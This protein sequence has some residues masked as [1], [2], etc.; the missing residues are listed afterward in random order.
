MKTTTRL[1]HQADDREA[2]HGSV[3][4]PIYH[5][6]LYT[7][8]TMQAFLDTRDGL[9]ERYMYSRESNP[10]VRVLEQK[11]AMLEGAEDCIATSSGMAAIT[12]V[13]LSI[14]KGGD[15]ALI[16]QTCYGPTRSF[17]DD[18]MAEL[19]VETTYFHPHV[20]DLSPL[21]QPN[22]RL[23][24]LESPGSVTFHI[25]DLRAL[26]A[27]ARAHGAITMAD[28]S[29]S[30]PLYQQPHS[31]GVD[32]VVHS[33]TK[34]IA[35]HSDLVLGLITGGG[36]QFRRI[37]KVAVLL[38]A[39]LGPAEA[40]LALRSLRTLSVRMAQLQQ[41]TMAVT[42]WLQAHSKVRK[43]LYPGLPSFPRHELAKTQ[44]SGWSSLFTVELQPPLDPEQR[45]NFVDG[46]EL[47]SV[48]VSWGGYES[49][50]VPLLSIN[51]NSMSAEE[52]LGLNDNCYRLCIGL[53]DAGDLI[54]DLK[55]A[56]SHYIIAP[57]G[58]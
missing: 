39:T 32:F 20:T 46:C 17:M 31:L 40:Y 38:G 14:L 18:I 33:G 54:A 8:P 53:E 6:S 1:L 57:K 28:N 37:K 47:F 27:H 10:T 52:R 45:H 42:T 50:I 12:A 19:G 9:E 36:D 58:L 13:L 26:S 48:G 11:I 22:T 3:N 4:P 25:Q 5:S 51:L 34:Y 43:V 24:Y 35:G 21:L 23:V 56:L 55:Q 41:N 44:M 29:W 7:F 15:H 30:T 49:L 16:V 2:Q